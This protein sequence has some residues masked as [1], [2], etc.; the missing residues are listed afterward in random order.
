[1]TSSSRLLLVG[2]DLQ[3]L[4][5]RRLD[6]A[7]AARA[8]GYDVHIAIPPGP[9]LGELQ[10]RG[11]AV[12]P[13][14]L[15]RR[16]LDPLREAR[17][18]LA[19]R[20]LYRHVRPDLVHHFTI[21]P[22]IY[23]G[24]AARRLGIP[25]VNS[26]TGM[27]SAFLMTG[28]R[29]RLLRSVL[30]PLYR[31]AL[32]G[33]AGRT[34][35]QNPDD[36]DLFVRRGLVAADRAELILGSGVDTQRFQPQAEPE[37]PVTVLF[38]GR[39]LKDKGAMEFVAAARLLA[40]RGPGVR[41]AMAGGP[42]PGNPSA[43]DDATVEGWR[44]EN[45]VEF[46][47]WQSDMALALARCHIVCLPS[48][49]EGIPRALLEAAACGRP[50][51]ATDVPGCREVCQ[52]G[53]TGVLVPPRDPAA[54]AGAIGRLAAD[55]GLRHRLGQGAR[56]F[57]EERFSSDRIHAQVLAVYDRLLAGR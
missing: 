53:A 33:P 11:Y 17:T 48:Y 55:A 22:V 13:F 10:A 56:R 52:D 44:K 20:R 28:A 40:A 27:G 41:M 30:R 39:F 23:G 38:V 2:N 37:G 32:G 7:D 31:A 24:I 8:A 45:A 35:F 42:D 36:R 25:R 26:I 21:K 51:V 34:V 57:V 1:M 43:I 18:F 5:S 12:H 19:L 47:G 16:S 50:L 29:G 49:R 14:P 9:R 54:L 3:D 6:L 46:W 4:L 15:A